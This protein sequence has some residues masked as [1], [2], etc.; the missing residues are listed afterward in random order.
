RVHLLFI[1]SGSEGG[2]RE[3]ILKIFN[4]CFYQKKNPRHSEAGVNPSGCIYCLFWGRWLLSGQFV[5]SYLN[6]QLAAYRSI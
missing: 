5:S 6:F 4:G 1:S 3:R 2:I